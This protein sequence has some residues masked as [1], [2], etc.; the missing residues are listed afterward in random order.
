MRVNPAEIYTLIKEIFLI[1]DEGDNYLFSQHGLSVTRFYA[2]HHLSSQPGLSLRDLSDLMLTD[3]SN[4]TR[5]VRTLESDGLI[6]RQQHES[7]GRSLRLFL[8]SNGEA[9]YEK[10]HA[11]HTLFNQMR[12]ATSLEDVEDHNVIEVLEDLKHKV[13]AEFKR[14]VEERIPT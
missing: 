12:F 4:V 2:L 14:I 7:D 11:E 8:T 10:V 9:L 3:K 13:S 1:L 6:K 5:F